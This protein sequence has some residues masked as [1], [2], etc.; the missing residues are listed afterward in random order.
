[1]SVGHSHDVHDGILKVGVGNIDGIVGD[2]I[3]GARK[4]G[5]NVVVLGRKTLERDC[6]HDSR[7][8]IGAG[9]W[10]IEDTWKGQILRRI[11][12]IRH[13]DV[14][15]GVVSNKVG[16]KANRQES[17]TKQNANW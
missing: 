6:V 5:S 2:A 4:S 15:V 17:P 3:F 14:V 8:S 7:S 13:R 9:D 10:L 11:A 16:K 12:K 1:M